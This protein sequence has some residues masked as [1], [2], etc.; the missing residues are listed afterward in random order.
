MKRYLVLLL[1]GS[2][3]YAAPVT[4]ESRTPGTFHGVELKGA[5]A[6]EIR[7]D[8][9]TSV[10]VTGES[11][12]LK[13]ISTDV[14]SGTLV[15]DMQ[16]TIRGSKSLKVAVTTPSLDA[17]SLSG[18]GTIHVQG[19]RSQRFAIEAAGSGTLDVSG[20]VAELAVDLGGA[21]DIKA[22][23]LPAKVVTVTLGGTGNA[24]L[25]ATDKLA[26]SVSGV[27]NVTVYGH[28]KSVTK[29]VTGVGSIK[30]R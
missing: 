14:K 1:A 22:K 9:T 19:V 15:I 17:V 24:T 10:E 13:Q 30:L 29:S 2:S 8:N 18:A 21:A 3:A 23:D 28:P 6:V 4:T 27:G 25:T 16:G 20:A 7:V 5:L 26:A 12:V 11:D